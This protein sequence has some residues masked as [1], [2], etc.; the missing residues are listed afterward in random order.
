VQR[1]LS[2]VMF[3]ALLWGAVP[4][5][6]APLPSTPSAPSKPAVAFVGTGTP[7]S[8]TAGT[9]NTVLGQVQASGG[10]EIGFDCGL[11]PH[12]I[13]ISPTLVITS[14]V[15]F[16]GGQLGRITLSGGSLRQ[17][18][19]AL[20][21]SHLALEDL[22]LTNGVVGDGYGGC[23]FVIAAQLQLLRVI[24]HTCRAGP[25]LTQAQAEGGPPIVGGTT[26]TGGAIANLSGTTSISASQILSSTAD[27]GGGLFN[28]GVLTLTNS[29]VAGNHAQYT[30]GGLD[31]AGQALIASS[32]IEHNLANAGGGVSTFLS[33]H[34]R[35]ETSRLYS[36][37]A[38]LAGGG[39]YSANLLTVTQTIFEQNATGNTGDGGGLYVYTGT[40]A[41]TETRFI[42]NQAHV[43]G[44]LFVLNGGLS[45]TQALVDGNQA[46]DGGGVAN[47]GGRVTLAAVTLSHN[48]ASSDGGG[49]YDTGP[50]GWSALTNVTV[51]GNTAGGVAGGIKSIKTLTMT[52]VTVANNVSFSNGAGFY[53]TNNSFPYTWHNVLLANN[54]ASGGSFNC[55]GALPNSEA[56]SLSGDATCIS[57]QGVNAALPLGPLQIN[58]G[59]GGFL[60]PTHLLLAGSEA[61][62]GGYGPYCPPADQRSAARPAG[63]ACDVGALESNAVLPWLWLPLVVR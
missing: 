61:I 42:D 25:P 7:D 14:Q 62:D 56:G 28:N 49:Y 3:V 50:I 54:Q 15:T 17:I 21:G 38:T 8:C 19:V 23:I 63:A 36:N 22:V 6:A 13:V 60:M 45:L 53:R 55:A 30:G 47:D 26:S 32:L 52:H 46:S 43:G 29:R 37:T 59:L 35:L 1:I 34:L 2:R 5:A 44:G 40:A 10:G 57:G 4:A 18:F 31:L 27:Q 51:S 11:A 24:V 41:L 48:Q 12:T 9:L 39:L 58:G 33:T 16:R 20:T